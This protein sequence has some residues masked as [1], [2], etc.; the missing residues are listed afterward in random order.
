MES[1]GAMTPVE[2]PPASHKHR[3]RKRKSSTTKTSAGKSRR[4]KRRSRRKRSTST[5]TSSSDSSSGSKRRKKRKKSA[6]WSTRDVLKLLNS[7]QKDSKS[8]SSTHKLSNNN[9]SNVVPE[10]DPSSKSQSIDSWVRKV[11]ECATIYDWDQKQTIHFALQKLTGLAKK[12]FEALPSVVFSWTEWQ[13]KLKKAFPNEQNYGRLL[14]EMLA[15]TSRINENLREYFYDKL[16]LINRCDI[17][18]KKAVDCIIHGIVDSSIYGM[19]HKPSNVRNR[20]I[21]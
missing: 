10:F 3:A 13:A 8:N 15:R 16:T 2:E 18:G 21:F 12:W 14:E 17:S 4:A 9:L 6:G 11:N 20:R 7:V 5:S 19:V 1:D